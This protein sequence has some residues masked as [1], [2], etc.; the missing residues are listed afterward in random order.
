[1][2]ALHVPL[3]GQALSLNQGIILTFAS[4]HAEVDPCRVSVIASLLKS[5]SPAGKRLTPMLAICVQGWL[6]RVGLLLGRNA[7]GIA[8]G[9]ALLSVWAFAQPLLLAHLIFGQ[10]LWG[11]VEK[12]WYEVAHFLGF[13]VEWGADLIVS[14]VIGKAVFAVGL[15]LLAWWGGPALEA[16]YAGKLQSL[17]RIP[18][19]R[20]PTLPPWRG[21]LRDLASPWFVVSLVLSGIYFWVSGKEVWLY[22]LRPLAVGW[23][24]FWAIRLFPLA[25]F[26]KLEAIWLQSRSRT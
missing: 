12:L 5:L 18:R 15:G 19:P 14:V 11:A 20:R 2:H 24:V 21:A 26:P 13:P 4:R 16:R 1:M 7:L 17:P 8:A 22:L 25:R 10:E 3:A 6:F 9:M 23:L